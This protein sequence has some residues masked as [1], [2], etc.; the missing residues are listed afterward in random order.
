MQP[1]QQ[2]LPPIITD[3]VIR[4]AAAC[5]RW[6][7]LPSPAEQNE[8]ERETSTYSIS[9]ACFFFFFLPVV[10][11]KWTNGYQCSEGKSPI[12]LPG[13]PSWYYFLR[14]RQE[15]KF[16]CAEYHLAST[17]PPPHPLYLFIRTSFTEGER[18]REQGAS[19]PSPNREV[20]SSN[21]TAYTSR[22]IHA[23]I[24]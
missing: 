23:A 14:T 2:T 15:M 13:F 8:K 20:V 1:M 3:S 6:N 4:T 11:R 10:V 22:L 7:R 19:S 9:A 16:L 18:E 12:S 24:E 21:N 5:W 17:S